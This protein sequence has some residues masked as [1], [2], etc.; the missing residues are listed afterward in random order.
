MVFSCHLLLQLCWSF[1]HTCAQA[2]DA[3]CPLPT[4]RVIPV[5]PWPSSY[6]TPGPVPMGLDKPFLLA[7]VDGL[8]E[9]WV[10][11]HDGGICALG[12][13]CPFGLVGVVGSLVAKHVADQEHQGAE[14]GEDHHCDDAYTEEERKDATS[15]YNTRFWHKEM[16]PQ[17]LQ[18]EP[19]LHHH[20]YLVSATLVFIHSFCYIQNVTERSLLVTFISQVNFNMNIY[21]R[22]WALPTVRQRVLSAPKTRGWKG[23][24]SRPGQIFLWGWGHWCILSSQWPYR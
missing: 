12:W 8:R 16:I 21:L 5:P 24:I 17:L 15:E 13:L 20:S 6:P 7:L 4:A 3:E 19:K 10:I 11:V 22:W 1:Y 9:V 23:D 2:S 18:A 14:D